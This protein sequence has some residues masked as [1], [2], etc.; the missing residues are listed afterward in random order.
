MPIQPYPLFYDSVV[1]ALQNPPYNWIGKTG[2]ELATK[3]KNITE[4]CHAD[5]SLPAKCAQQI[6]DMHMSRRINY[7]TTNLI[8]SPICKRRIK[9]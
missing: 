8:T 3:Y 7:K 5:D 2:Y 1:K 9:T 4:R 6:N